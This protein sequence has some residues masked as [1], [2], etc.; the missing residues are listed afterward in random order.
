MK[1]V[2]MWVLPIKARPAGW[3]GTAYYTSTDASRIMR[4]GWDA[5][6]C[7]PWYCVLS[8]TRSPAT[9]HPRD[10]GRHGQRTN[11][12]MAGRMSTPR[13]TSENGE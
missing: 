9:R 11:K 1:M 8:Q 3:T 6:L 13:Y 10:D 5:D 12:L 2:I 7:R 4:A